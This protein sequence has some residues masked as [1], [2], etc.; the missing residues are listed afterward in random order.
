MLWS[1]RDYAGGEARTT[2]TPE[3]ARR[4]LVLDGD[5]SGEDDADREDTDDDET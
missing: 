1:L 2:E 3:T 4:P 5:G